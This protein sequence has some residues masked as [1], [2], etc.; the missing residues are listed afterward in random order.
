MDAADHALAHA[1][2]TGGNLVVAARA[3]EWSSTAGE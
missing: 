2:Q 1:A 3:L